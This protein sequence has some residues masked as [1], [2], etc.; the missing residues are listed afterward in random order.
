[1]TFFGVTSKGSV[2]RPN[3][4]VKSLGKREVGS[5]VGG[6]PFEFDGDL[7]GT[8]IVRSEIEGHIERIDDGES[9]SGVFRGQAVSHSPA[10]QR[11]RHLVL[12]E[13]W[14]V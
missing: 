7:D 14:S 4:R 11:T 9:L 8:K 5:V 1:M 12:S 10:R 6:M 3:L 2:E 13:K